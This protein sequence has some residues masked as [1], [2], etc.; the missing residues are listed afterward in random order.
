MSR[1]YQNLIDKLTLKEKAYLVTGKD[2]WQT[3]DIS[4]LDI[5]SAFLSDG[6]HGVR[7]QAAAADHLGLNASI[8]ATCFPTAARK[9]NIHLQF[10]LHTRNQRKS[11]DRSKR[12]DIRII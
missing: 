1:K 11:K 4:R 9:R 8:P 3:K 10:R 6:P 5:P 7:R 2:F 12:Q